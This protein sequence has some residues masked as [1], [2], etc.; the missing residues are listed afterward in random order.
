MK[1]KELREKPKEEL[2][3][4]AAE[5][6]ARLRILRFSVSGAGVKNVREAR[7]IRKEIARIFTLLKLKV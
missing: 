1:I 3:R 5:K 6:R 2:K 4:L 7:T